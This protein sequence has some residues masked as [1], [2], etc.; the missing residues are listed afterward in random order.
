MQHKAGVSF[1]RSVAGWGQGSAHSAEYRK[2][3]GQD[4]LFIALIAP[5]LVYYCG[6]LALDLD[7]IPG[8]A[9]DEVYW[10]VQFDAMQ[11]GRGFE[12]QTFSGYFPPLWMLLTWGVHAVAGA[13]PLALRLLPASVALVTTIVATALFAGLAGWRMGLMFGL[14]LASSPHSMVYAR[15]AW[16]PSLMPLATVLLLYAALARRFVW[17]ALGLVPA[18]FVHPALIL[19]APVIYALWLLDLFGRRCLTWSRLLLIGSSALPMMLAMAFQI[20]SSHFAR[21][22]LADPVIASDLGLRGYVV[23]VRSIVELFSGISAF[24]NVGGTVP[25]AAIIAQDGVTVLVMA[26]AAVGLMLRPKRERYVACAVAAGLGITL[27]TLWTMGGPTAFYR[28]NE[29]YGIPLLVPGLWLIVCGIDA[30][31]RRRPWVRLAV[32]VIAFLSLISF[33]STFIERFRD[34]GGEG[35]VPFLGYPAQPKAEAAAWLEARAV[36]QGT[37]VAVT[38]DTYHLQM[39]TTYFADPELVE[40]RVDALR[41]YQPWEP[42]ALRNLLPDGGYVVTNARLTAQAFAIPF[43]YAEELEAVPWAERVHTLRHPSGAEQLR[44]YRIERMP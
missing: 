29:R 4:P 27:C 43:L 14:L 18:I 15:L 37:P 11:A 32:P 7:K 20:V 17:A 16:E 9:G 40:M 8:L 10:A 24:T 19:S 22:M 30:L 28:I 23:F 34:T 21:E 35:R 42:D 36:E 39:G 31:G 13:D 5:I 12:L 1:Q 2:L 25:S 44:I 26:V 6:L 41:Y 3:I 38:A 33:H